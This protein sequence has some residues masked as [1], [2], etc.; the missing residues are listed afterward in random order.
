[1]K[2]VNYLMLAALSA[3]LAVGIAAQD[4]K[5]MFDRGLERFFGPADYEA[6]IAEFSGVCKTGP[7]RFSCPV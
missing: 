2:K 5:A 3:V 7:E 1:M 6:A 4:T